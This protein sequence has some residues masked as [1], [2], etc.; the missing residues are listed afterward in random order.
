MAAACYEASVEVAR[1]HKHIHEEALACELSGIFFLGTGNRPNANSF[2]RRS[3]ECFN[4]WGALV[5]AKRVESTLFSTF[6]AESMTDSCLPSPCAP[7]EGFS[8]KRQSQDG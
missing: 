1:E 6:G 7:K 5:V 3:V 8:K 2:F 4:D